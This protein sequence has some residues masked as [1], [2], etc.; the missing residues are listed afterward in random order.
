MPRRASSR[1]RPSALIGIG[2]ALALV[3]AVLRYGTGNPDTAFAD[4]ARLDVAE[5]LEN[6][7]SLRGNEYSV[8]GQ[9]DEKLVWSADRGQVI[10]LRVGTPTGDEFIA[11]EV[12]PGFDRLNLDVRQ[13]YLFR[14]KFRDGGIA[15]ATGIE[16][17]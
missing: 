11:I 17:L 16:R 10:S 12:P 14:V 3:V 5:L 13:N 1:L 4:T 7:N 15:V 2:V 6:G 9:I 8:Q